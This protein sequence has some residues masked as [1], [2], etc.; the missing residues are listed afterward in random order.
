[1]LASKITFYQK[2]KNKEK[3]F[4]ERETKKRKGTDNC[5]STVKHRNCWVNADG[6]FGSIKILEVM[7][8]GNC[9]AFGY[10]WEE[11]EKEFFFRW[12]RREE[13]KM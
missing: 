7:W 5:P 3:A 6:S 13:K 4:K 12:K 2:A 8:T 11:E 9:L 1:M 10:I